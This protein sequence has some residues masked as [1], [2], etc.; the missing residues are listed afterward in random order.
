[1]SSYSQFFEDLLE[2]VVLA[3]AGV[4]LQGDFGLGFPSLF[5]LGVE[6]TCGEVKSTLTILGLIT[7]HL[8]KQQ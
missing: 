5:I 4:E 6:E 7:H 8:L 2:I 3:Q 1:M